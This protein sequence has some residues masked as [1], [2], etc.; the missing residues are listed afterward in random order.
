MNPA[1]PVRTTVRRLIGEPG[2]ELGFDGGATRA[3]DGGVGSCGPIVPAGRT[4]RQTK[5]ACEFA[6]R[7]GTPGRAPRDPHDRRCSVNVCEASDAV[8]TTICPGG[9]GV[10][11]TATD[12]RRRTSLPPDGVSTIRVSRR[13]PGRTWNTARPSTTTLRF[14][15][16]CSAIAF[17][18]ASVTA[19]EHVPAV[20]SGHVIRSSSRSCAASVLAT[21]EIEAPAVA[22]VTAGIETAAG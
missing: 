11:R 14:A 10:S 5:R 6:A 12:P 7:A 21:S 13:C 20:C 9:V 3:A 18:V 2:R 17:A 15:P 16:A 4:G 1:P 22:A 8:P 19:P